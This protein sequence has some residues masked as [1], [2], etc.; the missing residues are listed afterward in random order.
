MS[1]WYQHG[2]RFESTRC[3]NC[4]TGEPGTV[5]VSADEIEG[6]A[7]ATDLGTPEFREVYTR[8]LRG[9]AV[10]LREKGSGSCVFFDPARGC[11]VYAARPRQCRSWPFWAGVLASAESWQ[12][13]AESCPGMGRGPLRSADEVDAIARRRVRH[14]R[15]DQ[16]A[17]HPRNVLDGLL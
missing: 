5:L 9:G 13:E 2:L 7:A 10:S 15:V 16:P 8:M 17:R 6:L 11:S 4:C 14:Q 3:G 12:S 1:R